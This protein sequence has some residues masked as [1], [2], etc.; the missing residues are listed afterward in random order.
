VDPVAHALLQEPVDTV[1]ERDDEDA[2][3][4]AGHQSA[5]ELAAVETDRGID[6]D[7]PLLDPGGIG[8]VLGIRGGVL[9]DQLDSLVDALSQ[10][11]GGLDAGRAAQPD[12][13][14]AP[15]HLDLRADAETG[16]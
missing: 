11:P 8:A 3:P 15:G 5:T 4:G 16:D 10:A 2:H 12:E 6:E 13:E 9:G 7:V 14:L 1:T